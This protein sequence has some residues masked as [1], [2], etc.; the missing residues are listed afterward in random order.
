MIAFHGQ[1]GIKSKYVKRIKLHRKQ[2]DLRRGFYWNNGRGCAVG[3]TIEEQYEVHRKFEK[4]L[5]IPEPLVY[6]EDTL[7]ECMT[8]EKALD[9]P[10]NFLQSIKVGA[11]LSN[12]LDQLVLYLLSDETCGLYNIASKAAR[13]NI[14]HLASLIN[15]K[16]KGVTLNC[17]DW[18][19]A[20]GLCSL[21]IPDDTPPGYAEQSILRITSFYAYNESDVTRFFMYAGAAHCG[22]GENFPKDL[23]RWADNIADKFIELLEAAPV[24][25]MLT[26]ET[27]AR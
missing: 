18:E 11:D 12:V 20:V 14:M 16:I 9:F 19:N 4:A 8:W 1:P 6:L 25:N 2:D 22:E 15:R 10:V 24:V 23:S 17:I 26:E 27:Y 5:G 21:G 13:G 7:F 3:C